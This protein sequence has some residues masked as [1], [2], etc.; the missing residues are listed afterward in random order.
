MFPIFNPQLLSLSFM[1]P[2]SLYVCPKCP[3]LLSLSLSLSL[4]SVCLSIIFYSIPL[5]MLERYRVRYYSFGGF[6]AISFELP[7]LVGC[8]CRPVVLPTEQNWRSCLLASVVFVPFLGLGFF[9]F[10]LQTRK[11]NKPNFTDAFVCIIRGEIEM[12]VHESPGLSA[13]R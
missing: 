5:L 4:F 8:P 9:L 3:T 6:L 12:T 1:S 11:Q 13:R 2:I 10:I 7:S